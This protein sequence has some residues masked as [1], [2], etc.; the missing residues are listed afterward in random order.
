[1]KGLLGCAAAIAVASA[2]A[3]AAKSDEAASL[4]GDWKGTV[5]CYQMESP[6]QMTIGKATPET[7][8]VSM[9][10]GGALVWDAS[11]TYDAARKAVSITSE[12]KMADAAVLAGTLTGDTLS[13]KMDKQLCNSFTLTRQG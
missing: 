9:G 5:T 4:V 12:N 6:L 7:A 11:V 10:D 2:G 8:T 1:M 13:G 3:C